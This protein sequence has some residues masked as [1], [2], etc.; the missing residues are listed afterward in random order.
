MAKQDFIEYIATY[1]VKMSI[2]HVSLPGRSTFSND[3]NAR[4]V[5]RHFPQKIGYG[6]NGLLC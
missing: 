4:L 3:S 1:L 6:K 2:G 5:E